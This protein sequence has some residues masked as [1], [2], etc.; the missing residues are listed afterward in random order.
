MPTPP[1]K[2][3]VTRCLPKPVEDRLLELFDVTLRNSDEPMTRAELVDAVKSCDV[4][5]PTL[6]D[7]INSGLI[8]Q[9]GERMKLIANYG[10]GVDHIDVH[11]ARQ[12]GILVSNTPGVLTD[13]TADMTMALILAVT[14]RMPDGLATMQSG[15]WQGWSPTDLLGRRITGRR[16][17]IIGM[18]RIGQAIANRCRLGFGM[19]VVFHNRSQKTVAGCIQLESL[20]AVM[21]AADV[22]VIAIPG[23]PE[24]ARMIDADAIAAMQSH[25][26]LVNIARG[27]VMDEDALIASLIGMAREQVETMIGRT[28]IQRSYLYRTASVRQ[29]CFMIPKPPLISVT[30]VSVIDGNQSKTDLLPADYTVNVN[31]DP[32]VIAIKGSVDLSEYAAKPCGLEIEFTAGYGAVASDVPLPIRQAIL[33]LLAQSYEHRD[34]GAPNTTLSGLPMMAEALLMPYRQVRL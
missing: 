23:G 25:A 10:A 31:C 6:N 18:G 3:I 17:G 5:V 27:D 34:S 9:A 15:N 4:L 7:R 13:D 29:T 33:L 20:H 1:L 30:R 26:Y 32:G 12:N 19:N 16:L 2:V 22:I 24:T 28:L 14:R 21:A 8:G 11:T